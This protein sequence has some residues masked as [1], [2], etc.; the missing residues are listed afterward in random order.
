MTNKYLEKIAYVKGFR[1]NR[2]AHRE[3]LLGK[4]T[5][6]LHKDLGLP[7]DEKTFRSIYARALIE[8]RSKAKGKE[9]IMPQGYGKT[10]SKLLGKSDAEAK[11]ALKPY[12]N[13]VKQMK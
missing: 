11:K 10:L 2:L 8:M 5:K 1:S 3:I 4:K 12:S 9:V 6:K 13:F 7:Y